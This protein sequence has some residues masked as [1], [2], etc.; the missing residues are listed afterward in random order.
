M[1]FQKGLVSGLK[2]SILVSLLWLTACLA[3]PQRAANAPLEA[4]FSSALERFQNEYDFPGI[5]AS[6][7][8]ADGTAHSAA[9]GW[10]DAEIREPMTPESRMLAASI[11]K[12]FVAATMV[13]IAQE[14]AIDLDAPL[15]SW[16]GQNS[17][18]RRLP[19]HQSL[20]VRQLLNHTSGL[21]NHVYLPAFAGAVSKRWA[22]PGN[23]FPP[24]ALVGFVLDTE[25]LSRPG[26]QWAYTDTGYI[27]IGLVIEAITGRTYYEEVHDQFLEPLELT[28]TSA[29]NKRALQGLAAG[30]VADDNPFA[31]PA[32]TTDR[33]GVMKWNPALEWTGGGL[34]S[35]SRD[36]ARW[37]AALFG[38]QG[39]SEE[40]LNTMLQPVPI[41]E[42]MPGTYYGLG[43]SISRSGPLAPVYGHGGWIPGY[44]S[45]L[46][47]YAR[48]GI[49]IA[50]QINS[51]RISQQHLSDIELCLASLV[52][53]G[54]KNTD[55]V[56]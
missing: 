23:P 31:F 22:E 26:E 52:I 9:A 3:S 35:T 32:K 45:S 30:Y 56:P 6:Y 53:S 38:G 44:S 13:S 14:R 16:L 25:A 48:S 28:A 20:T 18:F 39:V 12:T 50:F 36:L 37:G 29:S 1:T 2:L 42:D 4:A 34:V 19:N 55:C 15:A 49:T 8:L 5:T 43:V 47:Y 33:N 10:A 21:P 40:I 46:R 24:E 54:G 51:D 11:G 7:V 41:G 27:L 17:W